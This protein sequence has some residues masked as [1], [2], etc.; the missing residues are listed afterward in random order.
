VVFFD[1]E[2]VEHGESGLQLRGLLIPKNTP[3]AYKVKGAFIMWECWLFA[4]A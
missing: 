1:E 2:S 3:V 4:F